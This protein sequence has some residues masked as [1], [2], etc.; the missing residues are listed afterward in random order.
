M[1]QY[2]G[3]KIISAEPVN[4]I[5]AESR[6]GRKIK[7]GNEPGY[8]VE[9]EDGYVSWSPK[10]VFVKAYRPTDGMTFGLAIEAM[11]AGNKVARTGWNGIEQ[12]KTLF[13]VYMEPLYLP[14]YNTTDTARK[15]N[16]RTARWIG[17]ETPLDS[18]AYFAL[19]NNGKWQPGWVPSVSD[20]LA[21]DWMIV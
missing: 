1:K 8:L 20:C 15:V 13:I 12:G 17:E 11:R 18:Q 2:I 21:D 7:P 14:P 9:Y 19:F 3:T 6:L 16:D 10:D 4:L 5:D